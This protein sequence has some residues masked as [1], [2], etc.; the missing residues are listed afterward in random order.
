MFQEGMLQKYTC[1]KRSTINSILTCPPFS[2]QWL[3]KEITKLEGHVKSDLG[4]E[5][6][7]FCVPTFVKTLACAHGH[8]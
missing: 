3:L 7:A 6:V 5:M 8:Y 4:S 2:N 1:L